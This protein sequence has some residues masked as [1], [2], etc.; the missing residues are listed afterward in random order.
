MERF[1]CFS[2]KCLP[3]KLRK[4]NGQIS[5]MQCFGFTNLSS[6]HVAEVVCARAEMANMSL[7]VVHSIKHGSQSFTDISEESVFFQLL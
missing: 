2:W 1:N 7:I 5:V 4:E 3:K 6:L